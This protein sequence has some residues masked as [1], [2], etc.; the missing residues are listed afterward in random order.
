[1]TAFL[2]NY[3]SRLTE[4]Y[5]RVPALYFSER[6]CEQPPENKRNVQNLLDVLRRVLEQLRTRQQ[7]TG[8]LITETYSTAARDVLEVQ[9][10]P[11]VSTSAAMSS[12]PC[13]AERALTSTVAAAPHLDRAQPGPDKHVDESS[14]PY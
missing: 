9:G 12:G 8:I 14:E 10:S 2:S 6:R 7:S 3:Q 4:A 5:R 1:M 11:F 13:P